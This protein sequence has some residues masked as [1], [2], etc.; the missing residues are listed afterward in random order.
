MQL[1]LPDLI[2]VAEVQQK[3][4]SVRGVVS[5]REEEA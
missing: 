1:D 5:V 4:A 2:D 3:L